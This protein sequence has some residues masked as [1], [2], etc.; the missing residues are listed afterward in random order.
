[1]LCITLIWAELT[2]CCKLPKMLTY[3]LEIYSC[4]P[5][6]INIVFTLG[7]ANT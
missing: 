6:Y 2:D 3:L 4:G 1:M 5:L 7:K